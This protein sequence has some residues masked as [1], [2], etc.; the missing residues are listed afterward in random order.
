LNSQTSTAQEL[1]AVAMVYES[2]VP[3]ARFS[4]NGPRVPPECLKTQLFAH[5]CAA[6]SRS[7]AQVSAEAPCFRF[8][9]NN[10]THGRINNYTFART[11]LCASK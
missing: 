11:V 10:P 8:V 3:A 6:A 9:S 2:P 1:T 5:F 7:S 4:P